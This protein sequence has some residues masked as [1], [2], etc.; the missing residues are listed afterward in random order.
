[1]VQAGLAK[2]GKTG[3]KV[4]VFPCVRMAFWLCNEALR[5][6]LSGQAKQSTEFEERYV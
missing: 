2:G 6:P 1:M 5:R 4:T 3:Q